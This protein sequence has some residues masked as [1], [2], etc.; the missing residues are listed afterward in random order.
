MSALVTKFILSEELPNPLIVAQNSSFSALNQDIASSW[1]HNI[2]DS[3]PI[4]SMQG[5]NEV[6]YFL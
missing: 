4:I 2:S 6:I 1:V 5:E 3:S